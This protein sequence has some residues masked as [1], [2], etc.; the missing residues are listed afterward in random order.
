M[1][2]HNEA[3]DNAKEDAQGNPHAEVDVDAVNKD[4]RD[5]E[6]DDIRGL[7]Y[8]RQD[9][10]EGCLPLRPLQPRRIVAGDHTRGG[11]VGD[12]LTNG[13]IVL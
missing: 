8:V 10:K 3:D 7:E 2:T 5:D 6:A 12:Q 13:E 4:G 11:R 9:W 1:P